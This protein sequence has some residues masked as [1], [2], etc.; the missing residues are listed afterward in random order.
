MTRYR[1]NECQRI[2]R[3]NANKLGKYWSAMAVMAAKV[4]ERRHSLWA[5]RVWIPGR[6]SVFCQQWISVNTFLMA[7]RLFLLRCNRMVQT[8]PFS[9]LFPI[10]IYYCSLTMCQ[11]KGKNK[12]KNRLYKAH[13]KKYSAIILLLAFSQ[14]IVQRPNHEKCLMHLLD[15]SV[16][17][18]ST[19]FQVANHVGQLKK[20]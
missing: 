4:V 19:L 8:L 5:G 13:N 16:T 9:F 18:K 20:G 14:R 11:E 17:H 10:I 6:T 12:S 15:R 3:L 2:K 7:I 1:I